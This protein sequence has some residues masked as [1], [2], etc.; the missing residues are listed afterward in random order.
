MTLSDWLRHKAE[1]TSAL[2]MSGVRE[3]FD[4]GDLPGVLYALARQAER[5]NVTG[6]TN[7]ER[8]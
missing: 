1:Y 7:E 8:R 2:S 6:E 3:R 5:E 4:A